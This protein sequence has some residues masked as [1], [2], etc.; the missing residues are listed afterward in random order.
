[1]AAAVAEGL[2]PAPAEACGATLGVEEEYHVVD[3]E[4]LAL[5]DD[6]GLNAAA[7]AGRLGD[8]LSAEIA[9]TQLEVAT[10]VCRSLAEVRAELVAARREAA[11]AAGAV[12]AAVL[13]AATHP[14]ARWDEQRLT[15][16]PRYLDMLE[17][18]GVLALQQVICGCHVHV[19][20]PDLDTAVAVMDRAR[21]HL[22]VLLALT[23]SSPFHEGTDTGYDSYR[24]QWWARWPVTGA[25]EPLGDGAGYLT[26]VEA[27]RAAG[28][29]DDPTHLYWDLRPSPRYPTLE[30][31]VADVC[32]SLDDAVLHAALA[33]SLTRVLAARARAGEP[34]PRLRPEVLRAARWRAAR[35]GLSGQL[36][37]PVRRELVDAPVAVHRLLEDLRED[38][39]DHGEWTE[40]SELVR[41]VLARGTSASRQRAVLHRT[42]DPVQVAGMLV[43][44]TRAVG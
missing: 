30:F 25:P 29:I 3:A 18:W 4:T 13:A 19:G 20:V 7:L 17:R 41:R 36:L 27:L 28:V 9:T 24:T 43:E 10:G 39:V 8:H 21:P 15:C 5:R 2:L 32:T 35:H 33:R 40:V 6:E 34:V 11:A 44:Q 12:G 23:G 31:R 1:M 16:R 22:P 38:L 14:F 42:G 26:V 37:D